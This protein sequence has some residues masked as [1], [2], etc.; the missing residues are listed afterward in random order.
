[1]ILNEQDFYQ[2]MLCP[3]K[4]HIDKNTKL[5]IG[6]EPSMQKLLMQVANYF[7]LQ[8]VNGKIPTIKQLQNKWDSICE[9]NEEYI[10]S[11]KNINGWGLIL[12]FIKWAQEERIVIGD[13]NAPFSIIVNGHQFNGII[14]AILVK[15]NK[16][17]AILD[18]SFSEKMPDK[19][20][21]DS[22]LK[23]SIYMEGFKSLYGQYPNYT[24]V[25]S[26][27][28]N[29]TLLTMRSKEDYVRMQS[30]I[31]NICKGI[32]HQVFYPRET[33]MCRTCSAKEYCKFWHD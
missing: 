22:K 11:K 14:P 2:Y 12:K 21:I 6:E 13:V 15:P 33:V 20:D 19:L 32:E 27:K 26:V 4:Y 8:L 25:H 10:D 31:K 30:T 28:H 7:F 16:E 18:L 17:V 3:T 1:M 24:L 9:A 5:T 29:Q 23:Y